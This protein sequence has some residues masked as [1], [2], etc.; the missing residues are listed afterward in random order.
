VVRRFPQEEQIDMTSRRGFVFSVAAVMLGAGLQAAAQTKPLVTV[1]KN[2]SCGCCGEWVK[3]MRANGFHLDVKD[4]D[5]VTPIK[6]RSLIPDALAS[7]HTALVGGY[8][9]E[10]HVPASDV[11]RMLREKPRI[12]GLS[13][14]GMVVGSPGMETGPAQPY[15][16]IAFDERGTRVFARH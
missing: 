7:C 9:I 2:P 10:G 16:T 5:D 4:V 15:S 6:R 14:P 8:A 12:I 13:V 11:W 1:Y 3:H